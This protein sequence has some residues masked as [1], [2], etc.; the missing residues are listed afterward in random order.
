MQVTIQQSKRVEK[1][2]K[3]LVGVSDI[4]ASGRNILFVLLNPLWRYFEAHYSTAVDVTSGP[5][6][7]QFKEN[8]W[9]GQPDNLQVYEHI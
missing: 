9:Y 2:G 7:T 6:A 1:I 3:S 4:I 8:Y 5:A